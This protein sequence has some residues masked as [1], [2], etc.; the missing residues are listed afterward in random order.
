MKKN[1]LGQFGTIYAETGDYYLSIV[2]LL[3]ND[4]RLKKSGK[5]RIILC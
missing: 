4:R 2:K 3:G 5:K 1:S